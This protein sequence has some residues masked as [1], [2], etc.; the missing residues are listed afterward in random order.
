MLM[1]PNDD[2][3]DV[4]D[5]DGENDVGDLGNDGSHEVCEHG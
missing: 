5:V 4:G 3:E 1:M 2:D